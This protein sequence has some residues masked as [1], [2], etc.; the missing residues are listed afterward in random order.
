MPNVSSASSYPSHDLS[1][2][3]AKNGTIPATIPIITAPLGAT[4]PQAGVIT[5]SPDTATEQNPSTLG[6]PRSASS[7]MAH[8]NEATAVASVVLMN[9]FAAILSGARALPALKPYQP[10][11]SKPVPTMQSTML[12]GAMISFLNLSRCP[13]RR[14]KTNAVEPELMCT[15]VPPAKSIAVILAPA[16]QTP[17]IQPSIPQSM[18]AI[19]K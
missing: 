17:V 11:Q 2:V 18:C 5:T 14:H 12:C 19:G 13:R 6:F 1:F 9:A 3:H 16:F 15:T 4:Y 10:T 7:S 8:V